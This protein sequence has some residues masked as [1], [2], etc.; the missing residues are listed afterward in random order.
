[1]EGFQP[2]PKPILKDF[3]FPTDTTAKFK[4]ILTKAIFDSLLDK[5]TKVGG[6]ISH[7]LNTALK[8]GYKE[9]I[10]LYLTD[11]DVI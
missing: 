5:K 4:E 8:F 2:H 3:C 9:D 6:H 10:G 11:A 1:M 7:V